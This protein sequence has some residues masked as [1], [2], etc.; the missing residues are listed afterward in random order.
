[1]LIKNHGKLEDIPEEKVYE[2]LAEHG[3]TETTGFSESYQNGWVL[4]QGD[5]GF[6]MMVMEGR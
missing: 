4:Y 5:D 1:M 6:E 3:V 2:I